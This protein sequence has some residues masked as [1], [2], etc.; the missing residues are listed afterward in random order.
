MEPSVSISPLAQQHYAELVALSVTPSQLRYVGSMDM[1]LSSVGFDVH[2]YV[3]LSHHNKGIDC[4]VGFFLVDTRYGAQ[5]HCAPL[6][7]LGLRAFFIDQ[8]YQHNGYARA[9]LRILPAY[10]QKRY[11]QHESI[12]L[13]V[14]PE[15]KIA[16]ALYQ[17]AGFVKCDVTYQNNNGD[18]LVVMKWPAVTEPLGANQEPLS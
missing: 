16:Q 11:A 14:H 17:H 3:V 10:L 5:F 18:E 15:H 1:I 7:A 6:N 13:T 12:Y 4:V 8:R 2:P 9:V